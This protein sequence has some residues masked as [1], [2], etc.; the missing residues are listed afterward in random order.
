MTTGETTIQT[1]LR[2]TLLLHDQEI[3]DFDRFVVYQEDVNGN[4]QN[5]GNV[6]Q[7]FANHM[8]IFDVTRVIGRILQ[9]A[10]NN[11]I[12]VVPY[13]RNDVTPEGSTAQSIITYHVDTVKPARINQDNESARYE[14]TP[15]YRYTIIDITDNSHVTDVYGQNIDNY[16]QFRIY[17]RSVTE[18]EQLMILTR[19]ALQVFAGSVQNCG[20]PVFQFI[21][22]GSLR[23]EQLSTDDKFRPMFLDYL[24]RTEDLYTFEV[25][26]V[27]MIDITLTTENGG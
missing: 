11:T 17:G 20:V 3:R 19:T 4:L 2:N 9:N 1:L 22:G 25:G 27:Q 24:I 8:Q 21:Q 14:T 10:A 23:D 5:L 16:V 7:F 12:S 13:K 26:L 18:T 15:R 6:K